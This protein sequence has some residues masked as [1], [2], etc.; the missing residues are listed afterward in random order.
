M[1]RF[2]LRRSP[3]F[4]LIELLVVLTIIGALVGLVVPAVQKARESANRAQ[5][6]NNL[7]QLGIASHHYHDDH[8]K[9]PP[10]IG[11]RG[12]QGDVYGNVFYHLLPYVEQDTLFEASLKNGFYFAGNNVVFAKPVKVFLCPSDP[13]VGGDGLVKNNQGQV[14]GAGCYAGNVQ[15]LCKVDG[16]GNLLD[17]Q[18]YA[19]FQAKFQDGTSNTILFAE[20]YAR[21]TNPGYPEGG[22]FWAYWITGPFV[23]PLHPG[24]AISWNDHSIE[25]GSKFLSRPNPFLG[26]C[27]PTLA[28]TA[29]LG[30]IQVVLADGSVRT[31]SSSVSGATWW[32]A[33]TPQG[34]E[35]LG[36]DWNN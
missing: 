16:R 6:A 4:T 19:S 22:S 24:F 3:G 34:G 13:S 18:D 12:S 1:V 28:S 30:G 20:K 23:Q 36:A 14:W 11:Y 21:C 29:H 26:N 33:C 27:D 31:I 7:R 5:C 32:A 15:V 17:P 9:L 25:S 35:V 10:G 8:G 2:R